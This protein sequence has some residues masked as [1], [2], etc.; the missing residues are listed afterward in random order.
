M[1]RILRCL[2]CNGKKRPN[3]PLKREVKACAERAKPR[4]WLQP[5]QGRAIMRA[6][7]SSA[8]AR[9]GLWAMFIS[10]FF[11]LSGV[12][13]MQPLNL[14]RLKA[15]RSRWVR[16]GQRRLPSSTVRTD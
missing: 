4:F 9:R 7:P 12:F 1:P 6:M 14:L 16:A 13:M 3:A 8:H 2:R 10:T 11:E 5:P 15:E